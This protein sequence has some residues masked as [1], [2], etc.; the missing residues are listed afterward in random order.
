MQII[1][2]WEEAAMSHKIGWEVKARPKNEYV[3]LERLDLE[4]L[5][6][7]QKYHSIYTIKLVKNIS[8]HR[9]QTDSQFSKT[10]TKG[11]KKQPQI[12]TNF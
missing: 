11:I 1:G 9:A 7:S 8:K 2:T 12:K 5:V 4:I 10:C 3:V 6:H